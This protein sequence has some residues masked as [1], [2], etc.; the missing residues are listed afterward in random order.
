M[1][2]ITLIPV[3]NEDWIL[4]YTLKNVSKFSDHIIVADQMS[5]DKSR[6]ICKKYEKVILLDNKD[7]FHTNKVRWQMLDAARNFDGNN[8]IFS[9]DADEFI[10]PLIKEEITKLQNTISPGTT[11]SFQW[12]QLWKSIEF[13]RNDSV[14]KDSFKPIAFWD[15]R[16]MNYVRNNIKMDHT[17]RVPYDKS[18]PNIEIEKYPLLHL[19]FAAWKKSQIKQSYYRCLEIILEKN[20]SARRINHTYA[21]TFD[22]KQIKLQP[23]KPGWLKNIELPDKIENISSEWHIKQILGWFN[24]YGIEKF[25][26]LEI[27]H[28]EE[29]HN[30]FVKKINREP[31]VQTYPKWLVKANDIKNKIKNR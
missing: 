26:P 6:E 3:K 25:E 28:I 10:S 17:S 1:K 4:D 20:K 13:Y 18:Y 31:K 7:K 27:W 21:E 23:V 24:E 22:N 5:E 16:I 14:W 29:L 9:I 19:Q 15:D 11:I 2:I 8:F 30:E 12:I